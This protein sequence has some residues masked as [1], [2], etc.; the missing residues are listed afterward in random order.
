MKKFLIVLSLFL[1]II[2][3][4]YIYIQY[5]LARYSVYYAS[6][7]PRQEETRP[8]LVMALENSYFIDKPNTEN[9]QFYEGDSQTI[10]LN[11]DAYFTKDYKGYYIR[12]EKQKELYFYNT[13][14]TGK[15]ISY[16]SPD[17]KQK[18]K[19]LNRK[20]LQEIEDILNSATEDLIKVQKIPFINL[21]KLF[22]QKYESTFN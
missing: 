4:I 6:H 2:G 22:N 9:V 5:N 20:T 19:S 1:I 14:L 16:F 7:M 15:L 10:Y 12:V 13:D 8:E 18:P 17:D 3:S 21:Q 11:K